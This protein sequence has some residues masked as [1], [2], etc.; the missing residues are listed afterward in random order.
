MPLARALSCRTSLLLL[1]EPFSA[2][3]APLRA[4]L[5]EE[6]LALQGQIEA[7]TILVT[8]DPAEA[9]LLADDLLLL[10]DGRVL[11]SGSVEDVFRR[12][13]SEAAARLLGAENAAAGQAVTPD[14]I[15]VGGVRVTVAGTPLASG[16]VGWSV[17]PEA[18]RVDREH[19]L[20]ATLLSA[21]PVRAGQRWLSVRVGDAV[22]KASAEPGFVAVPGPC[23]VSID[24][25][26]VQVWP[27]G[28]TGFV[29][30]AVVPANLAS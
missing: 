24:P 10:Q 26:A 17:R 15:D 25:E 27:L 9:T 21:S 7:T 1:D 20:P 23:R 14:T 8:H 19:G 5:R 28:A 18:I 4:R 29:L 22:L 12:P 6:L 2:L 13:A 30:C 11:Q 3:D 16:P